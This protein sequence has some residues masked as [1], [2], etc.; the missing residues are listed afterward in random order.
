MD[1]CRRVMQG[2]QSWLA[3]SA[4][5]KSRWGRSRAARERK[6]QITVIDGFNQP[7]TLRL[8]PTK[9][10]THLMIKFGPPS[11]RCALWKTIQ[12]P[13][14]PLNGSFQLPNC[15]LRWFFHSPNKI[16]SSEMAE[17]RPIFRAL[18]HGDQTIPW[19][20]LLSVDEQSLYVQM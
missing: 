1:R 13:T 7:S 5:A 15:P 20:R 12:S 4:R 14:C 18:D 6:P 19:W 17:W 16:F 8:R 3:Y 11:W 9:T 2:N 10:A